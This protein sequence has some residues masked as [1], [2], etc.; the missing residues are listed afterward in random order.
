MQGTLHQGVMPAPI[1]Q[2]I[3]SSAQIMLATIIS[4]ITTML[5][6]AGLGYYILALWSARSFS[7]SARAPLP[8]FT[9]AVSILKPVN[10]LDH[11]MYAAF[12]SHCMQQYT[13]EVEILFGVSS[14]DDPAVAA[15]AQLREEF[16]QQAIRLVECPQ[17]LGTNGKVSNLIQMLPHARY[18]H[19][20]INDSDI[21]VSPR[22]L[23][24]VM[25]CFA[26]SKGSRGRVG[27]VTAPY[28]GRAH[29][30][31]GSKGT[32]GS[33]MEAL[34]IATDFMAGVLTARLLEGGIRFGLGSTL[35]LS[36]E[37]L[38]AVGGLLPVVDHLAD[39]Y[40]LGAR[41]AAAG[42]DVALS[43]EVVETFV[44]A[45]SFRNFLKHQ[46]RWSRSTRD[47]RKWGYAGL[48][49]TFGLPWALLNLLA[50]GLSLESIALFVL[51]L[52]GRTALALAVGVGVLNDPQVLRDLWLLLP[53]D[54]V[55]LGLWIWSFAGDTVS[56][57]GQRFALKDGK[58]NRIPV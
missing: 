57:R 28:R 18:S 52:L 46:I 2:E 43:G 31:G 27:M 8:R 24:R 11:E 56:W 53:R 42:F 17:L 32:V 37:A 48:L 23:E 58:L 6:L 26:S 51:A 41:V 5:A 15:V 1:Q 10:G 50:S 20:L 13:G 34:G 21:R 4:A 19:V 30:N 36:R 44:P 33:K 3:W 45:Y 54:V 16:P 38:D 14:L 39:D 29:G 7:R 35:A 12:A 22:Y 47:S 55:A 40:E 49:F 25:A 9:P